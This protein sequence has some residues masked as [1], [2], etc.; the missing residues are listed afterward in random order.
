MEKVLLTKEEIKTITDIQ[1]QET[2]LIYQFGQLEYQ[3]QSLKLQKQKLTNQ[4]TQL[5]TNSNE[6]GK[7]LQ[8]KYGEGNINVETGEFIKT[9]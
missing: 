9:N 3:I 8:Q 5:Q 2:D 7:D 4:I 1:T 6:F